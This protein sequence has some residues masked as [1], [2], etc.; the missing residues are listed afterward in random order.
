MLFKTKAIIL[1]VFI[2]CGTSFALEP[3]EIF[4]IANSEIDAS[5]RIA[6]HYC[7]KRGVPSDNFVALPLGTSAQMVISRDDYNRKLAEPL[8]V[9]LTSVKFAG[10]IKCLLTTY[11]VPIIVG[12]R[13]QLQGRESELKQLRELIEQGKSRIQQ[14]EQN[15]PADL[16][17]IAPEKKRIKNN[18]ARLQLNIDLIEG[19]ETSAS[20]DSELSMMLFRNYE[21]YRWQVNRLRSSLNI[22]QNQDGLLAIGIG[23]LM[24]SRL[25][26]PGEDII[27]GLVDKAISAEQTGL[28]GVAYFD[29]RGIFRKDQFGSYD[30]SLRDLAYLTK[31][32]TDLPVEQEETATLF[33]AGS[34]PQTAIYCGW[35]SLKKYIDA[36]DFVDGA[37]GFHIASFEA[38]NLRDPNNSRWCPAMLVDGITATLGAVAEPYLHSFPQPKEFFEELYNG[39]CLVEAYYLTKPFNSWQLIL[40]GDP[41]YRPFKENDR[42]QG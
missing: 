10:K 28:K 30:Q 5:V 29:S 38:V 40:I 17:R 42:S 14:L 31:L 41:L 33:P 6:R 22:S 32:R 4:V 8:R 3:Q 18:I 2:S 26:G 21:L 25:D 15:N 27:E 1:L 7:Q 19:K 9:R 39:R 34:C 13:G 20:V 12:R 23:T 16:K 36:F 35:Y 37:V 24:V 11:G